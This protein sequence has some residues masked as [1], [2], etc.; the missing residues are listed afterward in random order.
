[1]T[2]QLQTIIASYFRYWG[3][4]VA[5]MLETAGDYGTQRRVV[6]AFMRIVE[7]ELWE[8]T[9][10]T[11]VL[12]AKLDKDIEHAVEVFVKLWYL[13]KLATETVENV[14]SLFNKQQTV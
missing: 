2:E 3:P 7:Q 10:W 4:E 1:M 12:K 5:E 11:I 14:S 8:E 6:N 13:D 9:S